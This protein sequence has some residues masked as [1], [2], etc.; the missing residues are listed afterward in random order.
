MIDLLKIT[1]VVFIHQNYK[2]SVASAY[3]T[4]IPVFYLLAYASAIRTEPSSTPYYLFMRRSAK[5]EPFKI[6]LKAEYSL[7]QTTLLHE[8]SPLEDWIATLNLI[9]F[10]L[11]KAGILPALSVSMNWLGY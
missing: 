3:R 1:L 10:I 9:G 11:D 6:N 5:S 4:I 2:I 7:L 8:S